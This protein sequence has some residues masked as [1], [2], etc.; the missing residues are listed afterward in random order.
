MSIPRRKVDFV[1]LISMR[2]SGS[3]SKRRGRVVERSST[4]GDFWKEC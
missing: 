2:L 4:D 3:G 1:G